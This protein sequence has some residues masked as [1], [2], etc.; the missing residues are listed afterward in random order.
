MYVRLKSVRTWFDSEGRHHI[1]IARSSNGRTTDF[2]SVYIGSN[3]IRASSL[4]ESMKD[5]DRSVRRLHRERMK[6][7]AE[8]VVCKWG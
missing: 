6:K 7:K 3:P 1:F 4:E 5:T 2:G 8:V